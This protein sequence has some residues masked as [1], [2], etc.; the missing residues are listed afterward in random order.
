MAGVHTDIGPRVA[1]PGTEQRDEARGAAQTLSSCWGR[2]NPGRAAE[3]QRSGGGGPEPNICNSRNR[4][5]AQLLGL[6]GVR[7]PLPRPGQLTDQRDPGAPQ[8]LPGRGGGGS[9]R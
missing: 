2:V 5:P 4:T 9:A 7:P 3:P 1:R 8:C 6:C